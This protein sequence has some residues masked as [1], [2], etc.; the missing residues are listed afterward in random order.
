VAGAADRAARTP[1]R[2]AARAELAARDGLDVIGV[3]LSSPLGIEALPATEAEP[4]L[5]AFNEGVLELGP[6]FAL[7]GATN[8]SGGVDELLDAGALGISLPAAALA[9]SR[10]LARVRRLLGRLEQRGAPLLVHPGPAPWRRPFEEPAAPAWW[11][12]LTSYIADMNEAWH[13]F[14]AWGRAAHPELTI[15]WTMLAGGA[16]LHAERLVARGGPAAAIHDP[17]AFYDASSYGPRALDAAIRIL[18]V[19]ALVHGSDRPVVEPPHPGAL[20]PAVE[21]AMVEA[22]PARALAGARVPA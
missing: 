15:V 1:F 6:P 17:R 4:L 9:D 5:A 10:G 20:G 18:G 11:P 16:P 22:N 21:H 13:A 8:L 3:C 19:D 7:W 12:A 2:T 14:A